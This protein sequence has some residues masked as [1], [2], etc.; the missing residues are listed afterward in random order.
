MVFIDTDVLSIFAKIQRLPLLFSVFN[1]DPLNI[2][3]AVEN[4]L[5]VGVAK[6]FDFAQDIMVLHSQGRIATYYP[7]AVD[8]Q[9]M[10]TLPWT[11]G[12]GERE[13]M[14][15]CKR[16][17]AIFVSNERRVKHHCRENGVDC[18]NLAEIL[19]TLWELGILPQADVRNVI[20][21]IRTKDNLEFRTTDSIFKP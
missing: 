7:T 21:E 4:E 12:S 8:R 1:E 9:F 16:L 13:S 2:S 3:A 11:L 14:A 6:G 19:R 5:Q 10:A 17:S 20:A 18:V 15:I